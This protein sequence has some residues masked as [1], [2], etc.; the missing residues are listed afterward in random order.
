LSHCIALACYNS[1]HVMC[2]QV[3]VYCLYVSLG[4]L[5]DSCTLIK[6]LIIE[7]VVFVMNL[8]I[9]SDKVSAFG[10][11]KLICSISVFFCSIPVV[12]KCAYKYEFFISKVLVWILCSKLIGV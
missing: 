10:N 6:F 8:I 4:V 11:S 12:T 5:S 7:K 1:R 9:V 2:V 3:P